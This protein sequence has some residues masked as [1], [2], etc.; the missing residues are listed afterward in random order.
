MAAMSSMTF[1]ASGQLAECLAS[2]PERRQMAAFQEPIRSRLML[3]AGDATVTAG[4]AG[5]RAQ[6]GSNGKSRVEWLRPHE[7]R[8]R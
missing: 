3:G 2:L 6:P 1:L 7:A 5:H 4:S 8:R